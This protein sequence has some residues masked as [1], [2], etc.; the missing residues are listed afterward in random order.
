MSLRVAAAV[1]AMAERKVDQLLGDR[2]SLGLRSLVMVVDGADED[3]DDRRA[4]DL[5]RVPVA[6][7]RLTGI[8]ASAEVG[9]ELEVGPPAAPIWRST[10]VNPN[11]R[12]R[13]AAAASTSSYNK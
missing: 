4:P 9:L 7:R 12:V 1:A 3:V 8:D 13:N 6:A 2:R 5:G 10:S 11:A